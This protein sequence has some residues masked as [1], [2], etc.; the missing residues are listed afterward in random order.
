MTTTQFSPQVLE[1]L[2]EVRDQW[3]YT[4][5]DPSPNAPE[6]PYFLHNAL[7]ALFDRLDLEQ[8]L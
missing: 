2:A 3:E 6:T 8:V 7:S 1:A 5:R 4:Q